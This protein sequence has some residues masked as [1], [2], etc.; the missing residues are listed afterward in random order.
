MSNAIKDHLATNLQKVRA[1]GGTRLTRIGGT[2]RDAAAQAI[3]EFKEGSGEVRV[4]AKDTLSTIVENLNETNQTKPQANDYEAQEINS[5]ANSQGASATN[6]KTLIVTLFNTLKNRASVQFQS[7]M[8]K[9]DAKLLERYGD[10]YTTLKQRVGTFV[11]SY[12][13]AKANAEATGT[14]PLQQKQVE[15]EDKVGQA[16]ASVARTEQQIR[17]QL[18]DLLQTAAAKL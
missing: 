16:G 10:R 3:A 7:Q 1:A 13:A 4:I 12:N 11:T 17:Q 8:I 5:E 14:D 2:F 15:L 6:T 9:L 18:K